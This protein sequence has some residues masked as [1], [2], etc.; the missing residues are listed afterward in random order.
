MTAFGQKKTSSFNQVVLSNRVAAMTSGNVVKLDGVAGYVRVNPSTALQLQAPF[1]IELWAYMDDW[2]A[3]NVLRTGLMSKSERG[4]WG[5]E[6]GLDSDN[7]KTVGFSVR[8]G[9]QWLYAKR[10]RTNLTG[11]WHH[12]T[13]TFDG[14]YVRFY[15]DGVLSATVDAGATGAVTYPYNFELRFGRAARDDSYGNNYFSGRIDEARVY[16]KVLNATEIKAHYNGGAGQTGSSSEPNLVAGWHFDE[17]GGTSA[18]DY[19]GKSLTGVLSAGTTWMPRD[20]AQ[21]SIAGL[22]VS[23]I[24]ESGADVKWATSKA[25]DSVVEYGETT[26]YGKA[27][28]APELVTDHAVSLGGLLPYKTYNYRVKSTDQSGQTITSA[29]GTFTTSDVPAASNQF[30]VA[31]D[32]SASGNGGFG[33]PWDLKTALSHPAAVKPGSVIWLRGGT[34][35]LPQPDG[36]FISKLTGTAQSPIVVRS[37]PGEWA[38]IDGN[39][40]SSTDKNKTILTVNG[41]YTWFMDFEI[42]NTET[43]N[44]KI[45]TA[46]SNPSGRRGSSVYDYA[47]GTKLINLVIHDT[48]QGIGAWQQ[49]RDNEYYGNIVYNNGWDAPDR[50]HGHGTYTQNEQ[51]YKHFTDNIFFNQFGNNTRTGGTSSSAVRN[52]AW[53]GNVFFNG[54]MAWL[55]PHIENLKV[56]NNFTYYQTFSVGNEVNSTYV[57]ADVTNNYFMGGVEL[58]EYSNGLTFKNNTVWNTNPKGRN[59]VLSTGSIPPAKFAID[60]NTYYKSFSSFPYW[61]FKVNY[62]GTQTISKQLYGEFAFNRT[63]GT[64]ATT[65]GYTGKTWQN[66]L[67]FDANGKYID[68]APTGTKVFV[69][70]NKYDPKG[71]AHVIIYNWD[72]LNTVTIDLSSVLQPGDQYEL[73]NVQD[74]FGDVITG[75]YNSPIAVPMTNRTQAKPVGYDLV[76]TWHHDPLQP[77][78]FPEF[79]VFVLIKK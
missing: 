49:G 51:G 7:A 14:R 20:I 36:K 4:A 44:R 47:V 34:Y 52:F 21:N 16:N 3:G 61:H 69:R 35:T 18:T 45:E 39:L 31:P 40:S 29:N 76:T 55:G 38:T 23:A 24:T 65:Y 70:P 56:T 73:R 79:G 58:F 66:D 48:G 2:T 6:I 32:G 30:Y 43:S 53:E 15:T 50:L 77:N 28:K 74:Y 26:A 42:T 62:R 11:G 9:K 22:Q 12:F 5:Y 64:Q 46:T 59:I 17:L 68:S 13:G 67:G 27:Q 63:Q 71:R 33:S 60:N 41:A 78:T 10:S 72:K 25:S 1:S 57:N 19:S 54:E 75:V 8:V 37:Y